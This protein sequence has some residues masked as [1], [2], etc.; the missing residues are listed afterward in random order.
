M[1]FAF[2]MALTGSWLLLSSIKDV[3]PW[4]EL[5]RAVKGQPPTPARERAS[6]GIPVRIL[7]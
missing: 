5:A 2:L 1:G 7:G 4:Q 6:E 3:D